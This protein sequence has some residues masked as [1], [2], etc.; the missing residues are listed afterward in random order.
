MVAASG[1]GVW[2]AILAATA[3]VADPLRSVLTVR[4]GV[5]LWIGVA[6]LA[7]MAAYQRAAPR[8]AGL[9][10]LVAALAKPQLALCA[11]AVW[12]VP[13]VSQRDRLLGMALPLL[14]LPA[15]LA[16][17]AV[18][19]AVAADGDAS[20]VTLFWA[21][22]RV[23]QHAPYDP[24]TL[25]RFV[26]VDWLGRW[27]FAWTWPLLLVGLAAAT[28][29]AVARTGD[30]PLFRRAVVVA[31]PALLLLA[32]AAIALVQPLTFFT[33]FVWPVEVTALI[34]VA[35]GTVVL[36]TRVPGGRV[37]AA[38]LA[39]LAVAGV[40]ADLRR[41]GGWQ[42]T[43]ILAPFERMAPT[44]LAAV[45]AI[46]AC[47]GPVV[48]PIAFV[49]LVASRAP[50]VPVCAMEDWAEG[51]GCASPSCVLVMP[52]TALTVPARRA[53]ADAVRRVAA[54]SVPVLARGDGGVLVRWTSS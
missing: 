9:W 34:L 3:Y 15:T 42:E 11:A 25:L 43:A 28:I 14:A 33:R 10:I 40:V 23:A 7:A 12:L 45:D 46:A 53:L 35:Y 22:S 24:V 20:G 1:F 4:A 5:D 13:G 54:G 16:M 19:R 41:E 8:W 49:P 39:A 17:D 26:A 47:D 2:T 52:G 37:V 51:R 6:L 44:A 31:V 36:A 18:L 21:F 38:G 32:Y 29:P 30:P 48:V 50:D 27:L